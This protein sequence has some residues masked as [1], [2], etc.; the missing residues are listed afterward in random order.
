MCKILNTFF[1]NEYEFISYDN[2]NLNNIVTPNVDVLKIINKHINDI[3]INQHN[4]N[5][6]YLKLTEAEEKLGNKND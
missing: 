1:N 5:P 4:I 6:N 3:G 2:I